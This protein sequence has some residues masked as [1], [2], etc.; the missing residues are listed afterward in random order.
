MDKLRPVGGCHIDNFYNA[1]SINPDIEYLS[2]LPTHNLDS[3]L[4]FRK[5]G[6]VRRGEFLRDALA[7]AET[8]PGTNHLLNLCND[9]YWFAVALFAAISRNI[10]TVL[11]SSAATHHTAELLSAMRDLVCI[12]DQARSPVDNMPYFRADHLTP[13]TTQCNEI[14]PMPQVRC[15]QKFL[16]VFTSGS[17]GKPVPHFKSFG[18]VYRS[19]LAGSERIWATAGGPCSVVGT[20]PLRHMYGLESTVLLPI[21]AGGQLSPNIPFFPAEVINALTETTVPRLLVI[22]PF[23]LRNLLDAEINI[24]P[25]S[26]I[27]SATA[28]LPMELAAAAEARFNAPVLEIYGSTETGQ[29][30]MRRPTSSVNWE[31]LPGISLHEHDGATIASG[32]C[33]ENTQPLNDIVELI[34]PS[35]FKFIDRHANLINVAGK[36]SS[37]AYLNHLLT[38]IDGVKDGVFCVPEH[39]APEHVTR[40]AAFVVA[41]GLKPSDI[42][43]ALRLHIDP[44]FL[45]RPIVF[46]EALPRDGNGKIPA[47]AIQ[48]LVT[49]HIAK[50]G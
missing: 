12:G 20:V 26:A 3:V 15:D 37:L 29:L 38:R 28:P 47:A 39:R 13:T 18:K 4:I 7:L 23:H 44:V 9:R 41:P 22:S 42:L 30:A 43:A 8:L 11:P 33:L 40:L 5:T 14:L 48:S 2:L 10:V 6:P 31:T 16:C 1:M 27:L 32:E 21:F 50:R 17:T 35:A 34:N 36:R 19:I 24:P 46:V 49:E 25:L 45:P